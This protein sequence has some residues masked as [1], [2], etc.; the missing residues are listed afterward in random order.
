MILLCNE[1]IKELDMVKNELGHCYNI[2]KN[3][4]L[5]DVSKYLENKRGKMDEFRQSH[6]IWKREAQAL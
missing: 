1:C 2:C 3:C 6:C 4:S 5:E